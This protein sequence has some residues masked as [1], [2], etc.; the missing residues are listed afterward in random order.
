MFPLSRG[1]NTADQ[2]WD[3]GAFPETFKL[4]INP[5]E[6]LETSWL[7][8]VF[9]SGTNPLYINYS[10]MFFHASVTEYIG[11]ILND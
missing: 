9:A 1:E 6:T 11:G 8:I 7:C 5:A 2:V 10:R 4:C 3:G